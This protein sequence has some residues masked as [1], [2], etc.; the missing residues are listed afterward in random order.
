MPQGLVWFPLVALAVTVGLVVLM[1][2]RSN[3][4]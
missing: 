4:E 2:P 1:K 3:D